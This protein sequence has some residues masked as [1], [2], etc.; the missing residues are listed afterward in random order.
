[1]GDGVERE[2]GLVMWRMPSRFIE[3]EGMFIVTAG[4]ALKGASSNVSL[5]TYLTGE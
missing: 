3:G 1:M 2:L 4:E 5:S